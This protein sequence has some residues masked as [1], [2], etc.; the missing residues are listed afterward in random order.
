MDRRISHI[1]ILLIFYLISS[2]SKAQDPVV[3]GGIIPLPTEQKVG[4]GHFLFSQ[5]T[6]IKY[7][8]DLKKTVAY[9]NKLVEKGIGKSL[10]IQ[11]SKNSNFVSFEIDTTITNIEGYQLTI[12]EKEVLI[13]SKDPKGSFYAI[14]TLRQLFSPC[15]AFALKSVKSFSRGKVQRITS[16]PRFYC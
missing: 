9:F 12:S 1:K 14:Q 3:F 7:H 4:K 5:N 13:R 16:E 8:P 15:F 6:S 2:C 11:T 10:E